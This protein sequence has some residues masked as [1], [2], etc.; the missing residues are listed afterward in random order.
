MSIVKPFRALRPKKDLAEKVAAP[1][2]DVISSSE[3]RN[4]AAGNSL[5]FLHI[6]KPEI[7]LD[8]NINIYDPAV[9]KKGAEN[10]KKMIDDRTLSQDTNPCFYL[11]RQI[12]GE[13]QQVGLVACASVAEY[14]E[15]KIK[16]HDAHNV[17]KGRFYYQNFLVLIYQVGH[18]GDYYGATHY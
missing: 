6:N 17:R 7:D 11:Y 5:S 4:M 1:P 10:L 13:H 8:Q 12:M 14:D 16:K 3:A 9:Y 18:A 2:Y 15:D